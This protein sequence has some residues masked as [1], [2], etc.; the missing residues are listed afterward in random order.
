MLKIEKKEK[1][2][3]SVCLLINFLITMFMAFLFYYI[4]YKYY[5]DRVYFYRKGNWIILGVYILSLVFFNNTFGGF[6]L[7]Y[8]K[9]KDIIFSQCLSLGFSNLIVYIEAIIAEKFFLPIRGFAIYYSIQIFLT[10]ILNILIDK[11]YY[12]IYKPRNTVL[13]TDEEFSSLFFKIEKNQNRAFKIIDTIDFNKYAKNKDVL[14]S[15]ESVLV[16][17]L[18]IKQK[19]E[20][21]KHCYDLTMPVYVVPDIYEVIMN[22]AHNIYLIDN[23]ILKSNNFGPSQLSKIIKRAIDI[24][25]AV[26]MLIITSPI[27]LITSIAIKLNDG[28]PI[29]YKQVRLTQHGR[30]FKILKFRSMKIDAEKDGKARLASEHDDRITSVGHFIRAC[31][32]DELP[33]L[34]NI[35]KGDMS[36]VGPRPERPEIVK[37]ILKD[38]PEFN[39]RLKVKAGLTGFAQVYGKYNT[40]LKDK[41]LLDLYYIENFSMLLDLKIMFLTFKILFVKDSTE[42]VEDE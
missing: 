18:Q 29:L 36:V 37:E 2:R 3:E 11:T 33:Q 4:W 28:G 40:K 42:G 32:I 10:V 23:P 7:G 20:I 5:R 13:I 16:S 12:S 34:I 24:L 31:R 30:E 9:M 25:F 21:I 39:Y 22:N 38:V 17:G 35:L 27:F 14:L 8:A 1:S 15:Y 26:L 19:E 6:R 41:L